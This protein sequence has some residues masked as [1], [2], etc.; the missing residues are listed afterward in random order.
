M[1]FGAR[2]MELRKIG[3]EI[4]KLSRNKILQETPKS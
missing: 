2:G 3:D 1:N 4:D